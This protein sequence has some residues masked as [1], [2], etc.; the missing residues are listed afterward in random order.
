[1]TTLCEHVLGTMTTLENLAK[2]WNDIPEDFKVVWYKGDAY[3]LAD[4]SVDGSRLMACLVCAAGYTDTP[5]IRALT[6][7][8][9]SSV[10]YEYPARVVSRYRVHH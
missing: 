1:M 2:E 8:D 9:L 6:K 7:V 3:Y 5:K 4:V 10:D